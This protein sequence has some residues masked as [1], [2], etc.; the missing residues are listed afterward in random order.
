MV[1]VMKNRQ[2]NLTIE[3]VPAKTLGVINSYV[4]DI[5]EGIEAEAIEISGSILTPDFVPGRSDI[6]SVLV[7]NEM[8]IDKLD[9][10]ASL[11]RRYGKKGIRAPL[12]MTPEYIKTSLDVFPIEFLDIS[13]NHKTVYGTDLFSDLEI[14]KSM[15]RIQCERD[16]KARLINL[17]QGFIS[18]AGDKKSLSNLV[19]DAFPGYFPIFR[20]ILHLMD[21]PYAGLS[22]EQVLKLTESA[23]DVN[24]DGFRQIAILRA[25]KKTILGMDASHHYFRKIYDVTHELSVKVDEMA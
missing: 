25:Q 13:T 4:T 24:M 11:G 22:R 10:L 12:F 16:L 7:I 6:N 9:Y 14:D 2:T 8:T 19:F 15:L 23:I 20:A 18:A 21:A 17:R 3:G 1:R 5:I